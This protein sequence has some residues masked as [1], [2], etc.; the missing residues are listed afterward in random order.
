MR[1]ASGGM[2][3]IVGCALLACLFFVGS[4]RVVD[5]IF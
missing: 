4:I 5:G 3:W 2:P 1:I